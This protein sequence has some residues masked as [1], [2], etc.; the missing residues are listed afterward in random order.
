MG[1]SMLDLNLRCLY[2]IR[3]RSLNY[4]NQIARLAQTVLVTNK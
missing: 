2:T 4:R 1:Q 3:D